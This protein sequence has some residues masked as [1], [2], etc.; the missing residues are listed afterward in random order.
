M[1]P[2]PDPLHRNLQVREKTLAFADHHD[3]QEVENPPASGS[4]S[5]VGSR[6]VIGNVTFNLENAPQVNPSSQKQLLRAGSPGMATPDLQSSF[7]GDQTDQV[8]G[9]S[10]QGQ[11]QECVR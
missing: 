8:H 10:G 4:V 9:R 2:S 3:L 11:H 7:R 1:P 6:A 5:L